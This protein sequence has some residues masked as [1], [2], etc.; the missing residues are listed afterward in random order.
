MYCLLHY[1]GLALCDRLSFNKAAWNDNGHP[2]IDRNNHLDTQMGYKSEG[3][4]CRA[5]SLRDSRKPYA[6]DHQCT[7]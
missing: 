5:Q 2:K 3:Y 1:W 4:G 6:F 7:I